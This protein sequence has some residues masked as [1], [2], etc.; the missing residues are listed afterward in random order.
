MNAGLKFVE[1]F[2]RR[3]LLTGR[4]TTG[5]TLTGGCGFENE[6]EERSPITTWTKL[7][8]S[9]RGVSVRSRL[10]ANEDAAYMSSCASIMPRSSTWHIGC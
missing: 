5:A 9:T 7:L 8:V 4:R 6:C 3:C 2:I 10:K 1:Q